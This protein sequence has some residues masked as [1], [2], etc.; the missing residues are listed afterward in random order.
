MSITTGGPSGVALT[1]RSNSRPLPSGQHEVQE[2]DIHVATG[3][4]PFAI[5]QRGGGQQLVLLRQHQIEGVV[6]TRVVVDEQ[7]P[8]H[9]PGTLYGRLMVGKCAL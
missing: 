5:G 2:H 7:Q 3:D 1:R 9:D 8:N 6:S 4:D